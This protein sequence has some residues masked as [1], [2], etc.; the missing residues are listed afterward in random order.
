ME[1]FT[2]SRAYIIT[3]FLSLAF[4]VIVQA[5]LG[6]T[7]YASTPQGYVYLHINYPMWGEI[8]GTPALIKS[9]YF[10]AGTLITLPKV[11]YTYISNSTRLMLVPNTTFVYLKSNY[12]IYVTSQ[13][14]YLLN[15]STA[16]AL[17]ASVNGVFVVVNGPIWVN[18]S[19]K[20][21]VPPQTVTL[22]PG[23]RAILLNPDSFV[24]NGPVKYVAVW[25]KQYY[26]YVLSQYPVLAYVNGSLKQLTSGWYAV[27]TR[28]VQF[29][30]YY[31]LSPFERVKFNPILNVTLNSSLT[32]AP[33]YKYQFL[34]QLSQN[35]SV[36]AII[37][38]V[39]S[40]LTTGWY[41]RGLE[42]RILAGPAQVSKGVQFY[43]TYANPSTFSVYSYTYVRVEGYFEYF[44]DL[45]VPLN[46]T[47]NGVPAVVY[48][49]WYK[50]GTVIGLNETQVVFP[51]G[52]LVKLSP[53]VSVVYV[54]SPKAV[55][56]TKKVYYYL[57]V[58]SPY[59]IKA[60]VN[61]NEVT[62]TSGW[63]RADSKIQVVPQF[64]YVNS[65]YRVGL[66]NPVN[67][68]LDKPMAYVAKWSPEYLVTFNSSFPVNVTLGN[69]TLLANSIW[70][71]KGGTVKVNPYVYVAP[72]V[73]YSVSPS[74]FTVNSHVSPV[75]VVG[76]KQYLVVLDGQAMWVNE[77]TQLELYKVVPFYENGHW[78]GT[79]DVQNGQI[80]VVNSPLNETFVATLNPQA[81]VTG[82]AFII[83]LIL[84]AFT[85]IFR[86][87]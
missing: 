18:A 68:T 22:G 49:G 86:K 6:T 5:H 17:N 63:M 31:Y 40:T 26:V 52:T 83:A 21:N 84:S 32:Y 45:T 60:L 76:Q 51:N 47:V 24:M 72:G 46:G 42:V 82:W 59:P 36:P 57:S 30:P 43:L 10:P 28:I 23:E 13:L 8:N 3:A 2:T 69:Q 41:D 37:N 44:V 75:N 15:L 87:P 53:S 39:A 9:G 74:V 16:Y 58:T 66:L 77:G 62:L 19:A 34:V 20:V 11:N 27:G 78:S 12:T 55:N 50:K 80:I 56:V 7:S 35:V 4:A 14:Q 79:L 65:T 67:I 73:R 71:P 33:K 81:A 85:L 48:P 61:G 64:F 1:A 29:S 54:D 38:G 25:Q 70:V